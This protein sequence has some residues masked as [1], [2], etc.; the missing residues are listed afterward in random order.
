LKELNLDCCDVVELIADSG[1]WG[2]ESVDLDECSPLVKLGV[3]TW[4]CA[5]FK[6][7]E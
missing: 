3:T 4:H 2:E 7:K 1:V 5:V 6:L